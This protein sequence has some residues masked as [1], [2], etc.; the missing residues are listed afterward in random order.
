MLPIIEEFSRGYWR[1]LRAA[2]LQPNA[3]CSKF[4]CVRQEIRYGLRRADL[5]TRHRAACPGLKRRV[6]QPNV[7]S[8]SG[9][10]HLSFALKRMLS[11]TVF[12]DELP[13][14]APVLAR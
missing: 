11:Q 10:G 13:D 2:D 3:T 6:G 1:D 14:H 5:R 4:D 9:S 8:A 12:L 7:G